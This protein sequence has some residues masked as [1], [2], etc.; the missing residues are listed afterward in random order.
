MVLARWECMSTG[1]EG[2][3]AVRRTVLERDDYADG[4]E[5]VTRVWRDR[6]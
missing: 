6:R 4:L 5:G 2:W 1:A 3:D